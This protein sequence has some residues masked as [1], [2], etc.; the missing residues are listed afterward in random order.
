RLFLAL[1]ARGLGDLLGL[2]ADALRLL[3]LL[4][5]DPIGLQ[6]VELSE[7]HEERAVLLLVVGHAHEHTLPG[8]LRSPDLPRDAAPGSGGA[9]AYQVDLAARPAPDDPVVAQDHEPA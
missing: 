2:G 8:R 1:D 5:L 4:F 6:L 7:A 3:G 9:A